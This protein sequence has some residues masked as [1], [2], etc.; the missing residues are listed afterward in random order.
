MVR[1]LALFS[2]TL[3]GCSGA[4]QGQEQQAP[5]RTRCT[6]ASVADG[7][8][9]R[10]TNGTRVRL[11]QI[12]SPEAGQGEVYARARAGLQRYL[13]K[14]QEVR[15]EY[16]VR[17][18]DQYGRTLAYVWSGK[19]LVNEA[20]VRDGWAVQ[21]TL[22]PNVRYVDRIRAAERE[23]RAKKRGLWADGD[24]TCRPADFRRKKC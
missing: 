20:V 8:T 1:A 6:V 10:C 22:P 14:G 13:G 16:D 7:D 24:V 2:V 18:A 12:D 23:A 17:P 3:L 5:A 9:F 11:L 4:I 19:T 21:F 15:L